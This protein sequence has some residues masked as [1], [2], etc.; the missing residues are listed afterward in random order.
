MSGSM[1][2]FVDRAFTEVMFVAISEV[3]ALAKKD[4]VGKGWFVEFE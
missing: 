2:L 3:I 1:V 4:K